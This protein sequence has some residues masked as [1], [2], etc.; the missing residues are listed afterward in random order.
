M[1]HLGMRIPELLEGPNDVR[2]G[3]VAHVAMV[4]IHILNLDQ[5][6]VFFH[7]FVAESQNPKVLVLAI[8]F[9]VF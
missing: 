9:D 1:A 3:R 4:Q 7:V 8:H 5:R 2:P 6:I